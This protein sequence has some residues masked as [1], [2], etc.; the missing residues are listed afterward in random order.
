MKY[1]LTLTLS[2]VT[3]FTFAQKEKLH[4]L[5]LAEKVSVGQ[6][7]MT[8]VAKWFRIMKDGSYQSGN[9]WLQNGN[10]QWEYD[11]NLQLFTPN[12]SLDLKNEYGGFTVAFEGSK[13]LWKREED[14]MPVTVTLIAI[15][16]LPMSPADYLKGVWDLVEI[17]KNDTSILK[18]FDP[19][20]KHKLFMRWDRVYINFNPEGERLTGY[21]HIHGH[22]PE[23]TLISHQEGKESEKWMIEADEKELIMKGVSENNNSILRKYQRRNSL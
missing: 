16:E 10:G 17:T 6:K 19:K 3:F 20:N 15:D 2:L 5:W 21:W 1:F 12:D 4:G 13:M 18:E 8:P 7:N 23:I 22:R 9:G 14:G 11:A